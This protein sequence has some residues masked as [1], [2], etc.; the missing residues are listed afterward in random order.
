MPDDDLQNLNLTDQQV[1]D[2]YLAKMPQPVRVA[3]G[4]N[5]RQLIEDVTQ[6][7]RA[8]CRTILAHGRRYNEM[9]AMNAE[10]QITAAIA[11][12]DLGG[13]EYVGKKRAEFVVAARTLMNAEGLIKRS[14]GACEV[15]GG[16]KKA[17]SSVVLSGG[18]RPLV[19]CPRCVAPPPEA[20]ADAAAPAS[21]SSS[22]PP[23][24]ATS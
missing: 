3:L 13:A 8:R 17:P 21:S 2:A 23:T 22:V 5:L 6:R 18:Q 9:L 20:A 14:P 10:G 24:S 1:A 4:P 15:C 7:E 11:V 12:G 16:T 19:P